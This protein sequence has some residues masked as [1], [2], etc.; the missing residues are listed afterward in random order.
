[1]HCLFTQSAVTLI[2]VSAGRWRHIAVHL[3]IAG[4]RVPP[5]ILAAAEG[6]R[7]MKNIVSMWRR[8]IR[9]RRG[10][11]EEEEEEEQFQEEKWK[12]IGEEMT[13]G[14]TQVMNPQK[15]LIRLNQFSTDRIN[16]ENMNF[17]YHL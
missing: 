5:L 14:L 9:K 1:M 10:R 12:V 2:L 17:K 6:M 3:R 16:R 8:K 4:V 11:K 13:A 7:E 15:S